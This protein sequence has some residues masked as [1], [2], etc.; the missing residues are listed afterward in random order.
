M[1]DSLRR[2][3]DRLVEGTLVTLMAALVACVT[4]QVV[5]RY[6]LQS[7]SS[8][9]EELARFLLIWIGLVGAV[10][11]YRMRAHMAIDLVSAKLTGLPRRVLWSTIHLLT[12]VF[13]IAVLCIGGLKLVILTLELE[14]VS[15]AIDMP[16]GY[17]YLVLPISGLLI[18]FYAA[19]AI[20]DG[21]HEVA[22]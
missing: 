7:P 13:A 3:L 9:T 1:L 11:A 20:L 16:F 5:S 8:W 22:S 18:A 12:G 4:W 17:V 19:L 14:Q 21:D 6:L 10:Y 2:Q 15:A